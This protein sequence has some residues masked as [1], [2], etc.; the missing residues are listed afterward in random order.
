MGENSFTYFNADKTDEIKLNDGIINNYFLN[1]LNK[2]KDFDIL[3]S[4]SIIHIYWNNFDSKE[5]DLNIPSTKLVD[6]KEIDKETKIH[7]A[8][9][10]SNQ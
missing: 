1:K 8:T 5:F 9:V 7:I 6:E 4:P 3:F 10:Q 2:D